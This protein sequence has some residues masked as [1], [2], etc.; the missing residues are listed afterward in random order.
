MSALVDEIE[1]VTS[2]LQ[3]VARE[4]QSP[5]AAGDMA[6]IIQR[7]DVLLG[8]AELSMARRL[9]PRQRAHIA[10]QFQGLA[11]GLRVMRDVG[12]QMERLGGEAP[13][14]VAL[15]EAVERM[16]RQLKRRGLPLGPARTSP[17]KV[18][19]DSTT[20]EFRVMTS[21]S[22]EQ[23]A[24]TAT[25]TAENV[26]RLLATVTPER[27]QCLDKQGVALAARALDQ[28]HDDVRNF[29][30]LAGQRG[31]QG[32]AWFGEMTD[33]LRQLEVALES[34][35][36]SLDIEAAHAAL[37]ESDERIPYEQVRRELGL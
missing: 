35:F 5:R 25:A 11:D 12:Q 14:G 32:E 10:Q 1:A 17:P 9:T 7:L 13:W 21:S 19:R 20:G 36:S 28:T 16:E 34:L 8:S 18:I 22:I 2:D 37:A 33:L 30:A 3:E 23:L 24:A 4:P 27:L 15:A 31:H 6:A 29:L 26:R